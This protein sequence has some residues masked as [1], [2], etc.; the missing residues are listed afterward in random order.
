MPNVSKI[1]KGVAKAVSGKKAAAA[2]KKGLKAAQGPSKAPKGYK[3]DTAGR[4]DVKRLVETGLYSKVA[5]QYFKLTP[6]EAAKYVS[7]ARKSSMNASR[8]QAEG[9]VSTAP[10][11]IISRSGRTTKKGK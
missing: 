4:K 8:T 11:N 3:P 6:K 5:G 7:E 10:K 2:N 1:V 9:G